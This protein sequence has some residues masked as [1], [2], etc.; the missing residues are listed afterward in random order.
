MYVF[1]LNAFRHS[2]TVSN[3]YKL[4]FHID[5]TLFLLTTTT[6]MSLFRE[7]KIDINS[8]NYKKSINLISGQNATVVN[9]NKS[10]T[11][12]L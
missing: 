10:D 8:D 2:V 3:I 5:N 4:T 11:W 1:C 7:K 9:V 6:W 12:D